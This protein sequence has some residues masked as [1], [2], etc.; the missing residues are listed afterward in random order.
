MNA[1]ARLDPSRVDSLLGVPGVI[2]VAVDIDADSCLLGDVDGF[3]CSL[4]GAQPAGVDGA[5]PLRRPVDETRRDARRKDRVDR[6]DPAPSTRL[7]LGYAGNRRGRVPA[8]GA[9]KSR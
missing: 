1:H 5:L 8:L 4:L 7:E 2:A 6:D 9:T 3:G